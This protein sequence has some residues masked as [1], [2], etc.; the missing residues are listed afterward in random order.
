MPACSRSTLVSSIP[1]VAPTNHCCSSLESP[2][3]NGC[4]LRRLTVHLPADVVSGVQG[5]LQS[6]FGMSSYV[7]ALTFSDLSAFPWL[8][9]ASCTVVVAGVLMTQWGLPPAW[10]VHKNGPALACTVAVGVMAS[11]RAHSVAELVTVSCAAATIFTTYQQPSAVLQGG[12]SEEQS[13]SADPESR[14]GSSEGD[15]LLPAS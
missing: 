15:S 3:W 6:L 8:M 14:G 4:L 7:A 11:R 10:V 1:W 12:A 2:L 9:L 5:S 13:A